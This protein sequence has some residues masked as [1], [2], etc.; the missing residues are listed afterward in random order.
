MPKNHKKQ[1]SK[2]R[3]LIFALVAPLVLGALM[4]IASAIFPIAESVRASGY[5]VLQRYFVASRD[6]LITGSLT[7][8]VLPILIDLVLLLAIPNSRTT[9]II[10]SV[11]G[12]VSGIPRVLI[13][14]LVLGAVAMSN[15]RAGSQVSYFGSILFFS[16]VAIV[17]LLPHEWRSNLSRI[18]SRLQSEEALSLRLSGMSR[19][20]ICYLYIRSENWNTRFQT[21]VSRI[22]SQSVLFE[23]EI[24]FIIAIGFGRFGKSNHSS[25]G[26]IM[27]DWRWQL[28]TSQ[29]SWGEWLV[30]LLIVIPILG[31]SLHSTAL[32]ERAFE[33]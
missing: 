9:A 1:Y 32:L 16:F 17:V 24:Q 19:R 5:V 26:E 31:L 12:I 25:Y 22:F 14:L 30:A 28:V 21:R 29:I 10:D 13:G 6:V 2:G 7:A 27:A 20:R 15:A 3:R 33:R 8:I 11:V 18:A 23:M 4:G